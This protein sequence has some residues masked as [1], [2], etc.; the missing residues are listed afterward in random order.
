MDKMDVV[1]TTTDASSRLEMTQALERWATWV[2]SGFGT[3]AERAVRGH[4]PLHY[5]AHCEHHQTSG[6]VVVKTEHSMCMTNSGQDCNTD[7]KWVIAE[8][9]DGF[10]VKFSFVDDV[11][12]QIVLSAPKK[13]GE[14]HVTIHPGQGSLRPTVHF[15]PSCRADAPKHVIRM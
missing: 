13:F 11:C 8:W 10:T 14:A 6:L 7:R 12:T 15:R 1:E 3:F 4:T 5:I 9:Y 2:P